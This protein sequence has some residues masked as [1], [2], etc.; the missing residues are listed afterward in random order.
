MQ[1]TPQ[2]GYALCRLG[3]GPARTK[4]VLGLVMGQTYALA[5]GDRCS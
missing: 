3:C 4:C 2:M 5:S 1:D